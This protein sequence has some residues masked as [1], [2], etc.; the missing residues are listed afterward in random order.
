[1]LKIKD[2]IFYRMYV[3]Y[4][5]ANEYGK[6]NTILFFTVIE[7]LFASPL[8]LLISIAAEDNEVAKYIVIFLPMIIIF[9]LNLKRYGKKD[10]I[11]KLIKKYHDSKYNKNIKMWMIYLLMP[12]AIAWGLFIGILLIGK[13]ALF[14]FDIIKGITV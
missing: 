9:L 4:K 8:I 7:F 6:I 2:Y 1:M 10:I 3:T 11:G 5:K 14:I 12:L 13:A